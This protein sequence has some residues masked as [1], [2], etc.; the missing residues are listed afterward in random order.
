MSVKSWIWGASIGAALVVAVTVSVVTTHAEASVPPAKA[1]AASITRVRVEATSIASQVSKTQ[2]VTCPAGTKVFSASGYTTGAPGHV[3]LAGVVPDQ[4]LTSVTV[5]ATG[6]TLAWWSVTAV[7]ICGNGAVHVQRITAS[8]P[9]KQ[10]TPK[11]VY[12][13]CP[14]NTRLYGLGGEITGTQMVSV[15]TLL[16]AF[17][18]I[19]SARVEVQSRTPND[20]YVWGVNAYAICGAPLAGMTS[21][22]VYNPP[23]GSPG[24]ADSPK[25]VTTHCP[26]GLRLLGVG[27]LMSGDGRFATLRSLR[28]DEGL[29]SVTVTATEGSPYELPWDV[30]AEALCAP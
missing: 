24:N 10:Q 30:A 20:D 17:F 6:E 9:P 4:G 18:E 23:L 26:T 13:R 29:T 12:A 21:A 5:R 1:L 25:T 28:P 8:F 19:N 7:A 22:E 27:G 2:T 11:Q 3:L 14:A 15:L 16:Q